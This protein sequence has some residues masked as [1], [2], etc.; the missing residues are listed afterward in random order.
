MQIAAVLE[1]LRSRRFIGVAFLAAAVV[2]GFSTPE[3]L[4]TSTMFSSS[5]ATFS[6]SSAVAWT[7]FF[8]LRD[9]L[10]PVALAFLGDST[11][12]RVAD[13]DAGTTLVSACDELT[14]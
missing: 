7:T 4:L 13:F 14:D 11:S 8:C 3:E 1:R 6:V 2:V 9:R 5:L 10:L 12:V